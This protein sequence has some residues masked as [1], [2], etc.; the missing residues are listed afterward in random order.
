MPSG[1]VTELLARWRGGDAQALEALVPL[2]YQELHDLAHRFLGRE[3][4]GHTL[5]STALVH[6]AYLR[7]V[8]QGPVDTRDR[9]HFV[10]VAARLMRQILVD[11]ARQHG[12]A[13]RGADLRV[14]LDAAADVA[15]VRSPGEGEAGHQARG[16]DLVAL[17]DA[18]S[19][20]SRLDER[21][22]RIVELR[23]FGGMTNEETALVLG[24]SPATVKREWNVAKA[25]LSRE[26]RRGRD[27]QS[28]DI[29]KG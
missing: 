9:A 26:I 27:D 20:L 10:A 24:I 13:K 15:G 8:D 14:D 12:A 6:E 5:Q 25:W 23:Y 16:A 19:D 4:P 21:Q 1:P 17:D 18:L 7:L 2:V 22:G 3:R 28:E 29:S 11:Y